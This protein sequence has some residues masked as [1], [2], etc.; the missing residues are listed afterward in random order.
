MSGFN[1][2]QTRDIWIGFRYKI[3]ND[4]GGDRG[5]RSDVEDVEVKIGVPIRRYHVYE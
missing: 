4:I 2:N 3:M 1:Q 5:R